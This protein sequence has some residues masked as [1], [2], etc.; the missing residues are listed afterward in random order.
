MDDPLF[1]FFFGS[2]NDLADGF[3][4]TYVAS[5]SITLIGGEILESAICGTS[6]NTLGGSLSSMYALWSAAFRGYF[7]SSLSWGDIGDIQLQ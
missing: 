5:C 3:Q 6:P 7:V 1:F 4:S 2:G